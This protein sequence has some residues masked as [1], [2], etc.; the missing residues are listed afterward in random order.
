MQVLM[1]QACQK[2]VTGYSSLELLAVRS[3]N[4]YTQHLHASRH[5]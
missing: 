3:T 1:N 5:E 4:F 2:V